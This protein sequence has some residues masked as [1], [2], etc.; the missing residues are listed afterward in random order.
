MPLPACCSPACVY[1]IRIRPIPAGATVVDLNS[2][3]VALD[4]APTAPS[5]GIPP[6]SRP[7]ITRWWLCWKSDGTSAGTTQVLQMG[8]SGG[9]AYFHC[10]DSALQGSP[11]SSVRYDPRSAFWRWTERRRTLMLSGFTVP[12]LYHSGAA[13][14]SA[15]WSCDFPG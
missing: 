13:G 10:S 14:V 1:V 15:E 8:P 3:P 2:V 7:R 11:T 9:Q 6:T 12:L 5:Q 4:S